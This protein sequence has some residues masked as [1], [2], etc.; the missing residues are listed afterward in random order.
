MSSELGGRPGVSTRPR[1]YPV[2]HEQE[3]IWLD[4]RLCEG[5]SR[6]LESLVYRLTGQL[7]IGAAEWAISQVIARHEI[8]R[9]RLTARDG[10]LVQIVNDP[11]PV[12]MAQLSCTPAAL[13]AELSRLTAEPLDLNETPI[14]PWLI[15]LSADEFVLVVQFH[16]AVVDDWALDVFQRELMQFYTARLLGR[17]PSLESLR[18]Q[19]GDYAVAQRAARIDPTDLAYWRERVRDAPRSCTIP[20]DRLGPGELPH[21]GGQQLFG[22]SPELGHAVRAWGRARRTTPYTVFAGAVAAL[23]W[24]YGEP[25]EVIFGTPVS[26]RGTAATD[27][28]I[29]CL[30]DMLP[31]RLAVSRDM[32]FRTLMDAVKAE[33]MGALEHRAVPYSALVR[34]TRP[35]AGADVPSLFDVALVVDDMRWEPL[36]LPGVTA[37]RVYV[38]QGWAKFAV[39]LTLVAGD[40]GGYAGFCDYDADVYQ[41]ATMARV[42]SRFTTLLARLI[43][44]AD[45][46][47]GQV[48]GSAV[49]PSNG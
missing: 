30:S 18:M 1:I 41:A 14:R 33:V 42:A 7:D 19:A 26:G 47:L 9:S 6:C 44:A 40:D 24:Q 15:C 49:E 23:L 20:P 8:L 28:M 36:S 4:D 39:S 43:A 38:P 22:V 29:G 17:L 35:G 46:P 31:L 48:V 3:S 13:P 37:E 45:E 12:P 5:Q 16:H 11:V 10:K 27:G 34:M 25:G 2:S 21:R 32:S